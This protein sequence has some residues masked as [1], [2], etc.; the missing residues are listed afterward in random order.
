MKPYTFLFRNGKVIVAEEALS[1]SP[2]LRDRTLRRLHWSRADIVA[3]AVQPL[4]KKRCD[5]V[6]RRQDGGIRRFQ[7]IDVTAA[8]MEEEF[9]MHG[10]RRRS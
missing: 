6:V 4:P 5:V 3:I 2:A 9:T 7:D 1:F 10:Y 8:E